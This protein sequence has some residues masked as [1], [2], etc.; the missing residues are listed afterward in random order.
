MIN[1]A[2]SMNEITNRTIYQKQKLLDLLYL[3]QFEEDLKVF[4]LPD[5][6]DIKLTEEFLIGLIDGDGCFNISF[7]KTKKLI[8]GFHITQHISSFQLL[9]KVKE[10]LGC[11]VINKKS[12]SVI[13]FQIDNFKDI[14]SI[15]IP[16]IEKFQLHTNKNL[17]FDIFKK[18]CDL[19]SNK[20]HYYE[21]GF[22]KIIELAYNMNKDGKR[23]KLT[24]EK[25]IK[26]ILI[27][28][29]E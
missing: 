19:I 22:L 14:S 18:V 8:L 6:K 15:L 26:T 25:Y 24:K 10:L 11:G 5:I 23:R 21:E 29:F 1:L 16:F 28:H 4:Q 20:Q 9:E 17:H 12:T 27:S 7:G 13:R 2:Y 3:D